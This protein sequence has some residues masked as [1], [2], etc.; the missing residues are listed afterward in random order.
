MNQEQFLTDINDRYKSMLRTAAVRL[1]HA[2]VQ[3]IMEEA[4]HDYV[5]NGVATPVVVRFPGDGELGALVG[6]MAGVAIAEQHRLRTLAFD[7]LADKTTKATYTDVYDR[8]YKE[9]FADI[10]GQPK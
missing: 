5:E 7:L 4:G 6:L 9:V 1:T 10:S 8:L 2:R 3:A